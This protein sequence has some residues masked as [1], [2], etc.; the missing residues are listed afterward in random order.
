MTVPIQNFRKVLPKEHVEKSDG[1][2]A[3]VGQ[4]P[5]RPR[6]LQ[7]ERPLPRYLQGQ[8]VRGQDSGTPS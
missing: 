6:P 5:G 1:E 2:V 7:Q 3:D 8:Q 4:E